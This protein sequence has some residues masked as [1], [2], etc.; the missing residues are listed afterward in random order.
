MD[1]HIC[2]K[3][4]YTE[5][6]MLEIISSNMEDKEIHHPEP[7]RILLKHVHHCSALTTTQVD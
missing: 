7:G 1:E 2:K 6:S 3:H 5:I 4:S